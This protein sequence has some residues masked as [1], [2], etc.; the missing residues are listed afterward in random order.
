[1]ERLD[2]SETLTSL[3]VAY[4]GSRRP[5]SYTAQDG[6]TKSFERDTFGQKGLVRQDKLG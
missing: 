2:E 1:M 6:L 4:D 3:V 5:V